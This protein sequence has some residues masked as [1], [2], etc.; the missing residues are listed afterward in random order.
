MGQEIEATRFTDEDFAG[1]SRRLQQET[2]LLAEWFE[3]S[4]FSM[5]D[6]M[7]GYELE[8]WLVDRQFRPA[9]VNEAFLQRLDDPMVV[10]ELARFN[11]EV[12]VHPQHLWGS[13]F[14]RFEAGLG[15][16]WQ[17]CC[18]TAA[19]LDTQLMMIG[20]LPT[21]RADELSLPNMS[22][23]K[24]YQ[25]LNEQVLRLRGGKPIQLEI[26]GREHLKVAEHSVMLEAATTSFQL[27]LKVRPQQAVRAYN[28]AIMVS[29][30]MVA[31]SANSPYLFGHDLW[32]ETR[33]PLFEQAVAVGGG[34]GRSPG[35]LRRVTFGSGY[36]RESLLEVF[37][38]NAAHYPVM[39][40]IS[41][42][43][44][45]G[46]MSC[47][48]LHNGTIWRWN[49]PLIG[50]DY[51]GSPHLRIEHRVV[52]A[53]PTIADMMANAA[54]FHGLVQAL[55]DDEQAAQQLLPFASARDNFYA[56][57]QHGLDALVC[58]SGGRQGSMQ[59][60]VLEQLLPQARRGLEQLEIDLADRDRYL[61]IVEQRARSGLTGTAWQRAAAV[62][63]GGDLAAMTG[64][65]YRQQQAGCPVHEWELP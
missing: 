51:D 58:W 50:F 6:R 15:A 16:T 19:Q 21:V 55:M 17:Q 41:G 8:A 31:V 59:A 11:I 44:G 52:P 14:S 9:P 63:C 46:Q 27:H 64:S 40:P 38:E 2:G 25:A 1:F 35:S 22:N 5:R 49:R 62:R 26:N 39:L 36:A 32:C 12:N 20:T 29:A 34:A 42:N 7:C 4:A 61:G 28:A 45:P 30:P 3:T 56:A 54:F 10:P 37:Q 65:Y 13:T 48:R 47:V 18:R 24:R 53:G 57:A 60:L 43:E 33:V 23:L